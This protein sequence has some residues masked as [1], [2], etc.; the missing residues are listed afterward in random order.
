MNLF[1]LQRCK[2]ESQHTHH[3]LILTNNRHTK[4]DL[5]HF[6]PHYGYALHGASTSLLSRELKNLKRIY[7]LLKMSSAYT[8]EK[9]YIGI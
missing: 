9:K 2:P 8:R 7:C 6:T 5:S 1:P 4:K 3:I